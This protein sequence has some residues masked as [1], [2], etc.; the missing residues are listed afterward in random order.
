MEAIEQMKK[1]FEAME[2]RNSKHV[3]KLLRT[4][5]DISCRYEALESMS[6]KLQKQMHENRHIIYKMDSVYNLNI[7]LDTLVQ[8][9]EQ[10]SLQARATNKIT[11]PKRHREII[12][13]IKNMQLQQEL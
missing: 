10:A 2:E 4:I 3:A 13:E 11:I 1:E 7:K 8:K 5:N 12:N 9:I 6:N